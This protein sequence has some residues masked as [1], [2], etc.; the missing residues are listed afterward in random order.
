MRFVE[1]L[2]GQGVAGLLVI[3]LILWCDGWFDPLRMQLRGRCLVRQ[4]RRLSRGSG[5]QTQEESE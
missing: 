4:G 3:F 5:S 1:W 2:R